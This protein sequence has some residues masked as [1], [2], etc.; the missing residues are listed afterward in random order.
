MLK[1]IKMHTTDSVL[2][3]D[4]RESRHF[5]AETQGHTEGRGEIAFLAQQL[6]RIRTRFGSNEVADGTN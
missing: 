3:Y 2:E 1:C 5:T 4:P 6:E